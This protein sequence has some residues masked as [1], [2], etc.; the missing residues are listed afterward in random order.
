MNRISDKEIMEHIQKQYEY[1]ISEYGSHRILG[2]FAQGRVN[3]GFAEKKE[4]IQAVGCYLPTFEELCSQRPEAAFQIKNEEKDIDVKLTDIRYILA[5]AR[6]QKENVLEAVF[7]EYCIIN[8]NYQKIFTET[9]YTNREAMFHCNKRARLECAADTALQEIESY[10]QTNN[11][12]SL[13]N[14]CRKRIA[15]T[16]Y[17]AG[18]SIENC[19]N[20]KKDYHINYLWNILDGKEIPDLNEVIK[21]LKKIKEDCQCFNINKANEQ[22][23]A[24]SI[25][26]IIRVSLNPVVPKE[27]FLL[28]LTE[29]EK[30]ALKVI[31]NNLP[32]RE[33]NISISK[34]LNQANVS[35]P[36][37]KNLLR[38][39]EECNYAQIE[40]QGVKGTYIKFLDE[41]AGSLC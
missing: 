4:D 27:E 38:K 9:I 25:I 18:T 37:F 36:V 26:E 11:R 34:L 31:V 15:A 23:M 30:E 13:F 24:N 35:R 33:G 2:V 6:Q 3:F 14:A 40:N 17:I 12:Y 7:T 39:M 28:N 10:K 1:L 32:E 21:D 16:L 41:E 20:L 19:I 8:P 29:N 22:L 5:L